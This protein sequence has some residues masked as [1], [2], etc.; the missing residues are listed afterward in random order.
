MV[1]RNRGSRWRRASLLT[2]PQNAACMRKRV[3]PRRWPSLATT[4]DL[5]HPARPV[6]RPAR[7]SPDRPGREPWSRRAVRAAARCSTLPVSYQD[8]V[9]FLENVLAVPG[10]RTQLRRRPRPTALTAACRRAGSVPSASKASSSRDKEARRPGTGSRRAKPR[11]RDRARRSW[12]GPGVRDLR[13]IVLGTDGL[14]AVPTALL[15]R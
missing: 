8:P 2:L 9:T 7:D 1:K 5:R 10:S 12:G 14:P 11:S 4:D 13:P 3:A 6:A 15:R